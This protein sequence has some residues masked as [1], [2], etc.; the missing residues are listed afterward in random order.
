MYYFT[1]YSNYQPILNSAPVFTSTAEKA[2]AEKALYVISGKDS[3]LL[4]NPEAIGDGH[5]VYALMRKPEG[6]STKKG[7]F[8]I[9]AVENEGE[10]PK[11]L[12]YR[13]ETLERARRNLP[14]LSL[15]NHIVVVAKLIESV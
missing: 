10:P 5:V 2:G 3:S 9:L 4:K 6:E 1:Q 14:G 8:I 12:G 15:A 13:F 7:P 11:D